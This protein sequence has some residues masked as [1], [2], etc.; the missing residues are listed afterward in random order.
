[1]AR[2][3]THKNTHTRTDTE[4]RTRAR[5][6]THTHTPQNH[7]VTFEISVLIPIRLEVQY[8]VFHNHHVA[9]YSI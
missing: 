4:K 9:L 3:R 7:M 6:H 5:A 8:R 1:M 2:A